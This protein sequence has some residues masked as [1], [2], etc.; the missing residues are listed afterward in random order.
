MLPM[1]SALLLA[2]ALLLDSLGQA[3]N[4]SESD[5]ESRFAPLLIP[6]HTTLPS[7]SLLPINSI[8]RSCTKI[9]RTLQANATGETFDSAPPF[10]LLHIEYRRH[11]CGSFQAERSC[12]DSTGR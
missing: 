8:A 5:R 2:A 10:R 4:S 1:V 9:R 12:V 7:S 3:G 11:G 6:A